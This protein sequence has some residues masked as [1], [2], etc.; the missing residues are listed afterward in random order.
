MIY[1]TSEEQY[2]KMTTLDSKERWKT[3]D[4]E[5]IK[6]KEAINEHGC[7]YCIYPAGTDNTGHPYPARKIQIYDRKC[8]GSPIDDKVPDA[9]RVFDGECM[10][11]EKF[12]SRLESLL[13]QKDKQE[14]GNR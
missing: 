6:W 13:M 1:T 11:Y 14:N 3:F 4:A 2:L 5:K 10:E 8:F 12:L 7:F 9:D